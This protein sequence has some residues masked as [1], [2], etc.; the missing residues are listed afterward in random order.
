MTISNTTTQTAGS[1]GNGATTSFPFT[2]SVE[3]Y[4]AVSQS[5]QVQVI[6]ETIATGAEEVLTSGFTISFNANQNSNPGGSV[7]FDT[8]P[9]SGVKIWIRSNPSFLQATDYQNQGGF[10]ME[11]VE[12][13]ADQ[14]QRQ[15]NWLRAA[16]LKAPRV[17]IQAGSSFDGEIAGD[18]LSGG[19][20]QVKS[21]LSGY[22]WVQ[23]NGSSNVVTAAGSTTARSLADRFAE[24]VR[25]EDFGAVGDGTTDDTT[26]VQAALDSMSAGDCLLLRPGAV[27]SVQN[28][29]LPTLTAVYTGS[30]GIV[31][32]G[33]RA[34]IK[35]R[36]GGDNDYLV[37]GKKWITATKTDFSNEPW[38]FEN[39]IF[40]ANSIAEWAVI[41]KTY[42][43]R[44]LNCD[45]IN[46]TVGGCK[47]T[48]QNQDGSAID[49]GALNPE[50]F[51]IGCRFYNSGTY[52]FR[53]EGTAADDTAASTDCWLAD[54]AFDGEATTDYNIY[55]GTCAGW[56]IRGNHTYASTV[57]GFRAV[58]MGMGADIAGNEFE[59][60]VI[61]GDVGGFGFARF[62]PG[63]YL[64]TGLRFDGEDD[65]GAE[66][67]EVAS[68]AF[69]QIVGGAKAQ[70]TLN[71]NA[72]SAKRLIGVNNIFQHAT[73]YVRGGSAAGVLEVIGGYSVDAG[74]NLGHCLFDDSA[75]EGPFDDVTRN[76]SSSASNDSVGVRRFMARNS[77]G[78]LFEV[79]GARGVIG[80]PTAGAENCRIEHFV[81]RGGVR[82]VQFVFGA[83]IYGSG[84]SDPGAGALNLSTA[85][86]INN[87]KVVGAQG[88]AVA[89]ASGGAT[90]DTEARAALN[91]L[92]AR[93]RAHGLIAT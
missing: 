24:Y 39:V 11:T 40:D 7:V 86:Y 5:D 25:P 32:V 62:G 27:Y 61:I 36:S 8:A 1:N 28:V 81:T 57:A 72:R 3:A 30:T 38:H 50:N 78:A 90:V 84:L 21:D 92:L 65:T 13:Q 37:A 75:T 49:S 16:L 82:V 60:L 41:L 43:G 64:R 87:T 66:V 53:N 93:L 15:I 6:R 33:G 59:D 22:E 46:G 52:N 69:H 20:P 51:F 4:G 67:L 89:D 48:R 91:A 18:L 63:N 55:M 31:C 88:A 68:N 44:Y 56:K 85:Y 80:S 19:I 73:P 74:A 58:S 17:G 77:N 45:F 42:W 76:S 10:L 14:Q 79:G 83:G 29:K 54:C 71:D 2:F 34:T 9:A 47:L 26:A 23:N 70:C 12:D 35:A